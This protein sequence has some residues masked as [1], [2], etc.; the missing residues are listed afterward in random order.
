MHMHA[1]TCSR[2]ASSGGAGSSAKRPESAAAQVAAAAAAH[3]GQP[4]GSAAAQAE[5][6]GRRRRPAARLG[7]L[8]AGVSGVAVRGQARQQARQAGR[9]G[10]V[11]GRRLQRRARRERHL[12]GAARGRA[13]LP[14]VRLLGACARARAPPG[15]PCPR[16]PAHRV[17]RGWPSWR[18]R[19]W[20][21]LAALPLPVGPTAEPS[22][23][24]AAVVFGVTPG[25][26]PDKQGRLHEPAHSRGT[27]RPT[28]RLL[29]RRPW[30]GRSALP[31]RRAEAWEQ[32]G[33][34]VTSRA[35]S[36]APRSAADSA[37]GSAPVG[38]AGAASAGASLASARSAPA[39]CAASPP[40]ASAASASTAWPRAVQA[41]LQGVRSSRERPSGAPR[42]GDQPATS[43]AVGSG[44]AGA[45]GRASVCSA[46]AGRPGRGRTWA[47]CGAQA[48]AGRQAARSAR[49]RSCSGGASRGSSAIAS[50]ARG[51]GFCTA[52]VQM[53]D[54]CASSHARGGRQRTQAAISGPQASWA[55]Q[56]S[57]ECALGQRAP[58][59]SPVIVHR[60]GGRACA[61]AAASRPSANARGGGGGGV[62]SGS[63]AAA[64]AGARCGTAGATAGVAGGARPAATAGAPSSAG[65]APRLL[66]SPSGA[67]ARA[68]TGDATSAPTP[69]PWPALG[70]GACAAAAPGACASAGSGQLVRDARDALSALL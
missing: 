27:L 26:A 52:A 19:S 39:R 49:L 68:P 57:Q 28:V 67:P 65:A 9:R 4:A 15:V 48:G 13:P 61:C 54:A 5:P 66:M 41:C 23:R 38:G 6:H 25:G 58:A 3:A 33:P 20:P 62:S 55:S 8:G 44:A 40:A 21:A 53:R 17:W 50:C 45:R 51:A 36:Q 29:V 14:G 32:T 7:G 69:G 10:R 34:R 2:P 47:T 59:E 18:T 60:P 70:L 30:Q 37:R 11:R 42:D 1:V 12:R 35:G 56:D 63:S 43:S 31:T 64:P 16:H 22:A 46:A 24:W